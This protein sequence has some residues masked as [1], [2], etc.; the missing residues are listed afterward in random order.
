MTAV[1]HAPWQR[2]IALGDSLTE[3][4]CDPAP[5]RALRADERIEHSPPGDWLGWADRLAGILDGDARLREH[6]VEFANLAV[7]GRRVQDVVDEQ[8]PRAV[9][10]GADLVSVMIGS[11][12]LMGPRADPDVLAARLD[13]G[14][15]RLRASGADVLLATSFDPRFA[16]FLRPLRGRSA[17]FNAHLWTIARKHGTFVLD[18]WG[19]R[20]L[21]DPLVWA[22]DRV[23]LSAMGHRI[24]ASR[25]AQALGVAY[26][27]IGRPRRVLGAEPPVPRV[28]DLPTGTWLRRYAI[29][30]LGRRLRGVSSGDGLHGKLTRLTPVRDRDGWGTAR[31]V[32]GTP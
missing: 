15:A 24:V 5:Q 4:F 23:H 9:E 29:P 7:R 25:A 26:A 10:L 14:V 12:D 30:W 8:I 28:G 32:G 13:D 20:E 16:P 6:G 21:Q 11:N 3:G 1:T 17:V 18:V 2:Y 19:M 27:E 22:E 31:Q